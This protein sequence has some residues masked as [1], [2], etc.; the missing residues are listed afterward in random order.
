MADIIAWALLAV[1]VTISSGTDDGLQRLWLVA[2]YA[3]AMIWVVAPRLRRLLAPGTPLTAGRI[4]AVLAGMLLSAAFTEW[5]GL[6]FIFGAFAFGVAMPHEG[7]DRLRQDLL[8]RVGGVSSVMLLPV[9]FVVA[10]LRVDLSTMDLTALG[11]LGLIVLVAVTGKFVGA[12]LGARLNGLPAQESSAVAVLM[13]TRGLT[14]LV[15]LSIGLQMG[16]LDER[17]YTL[18]VLMAL[19]TTAMAGP[20]LHLCY[21]SKQE[22]DSPLG[23][24]R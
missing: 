1:V 8:D 5:I 20:L 12:F 10:G 9:F 15:V 14:E 3:A 7:T 2:P 4:G 18:M 6:H 21:R 23:R 13:N 24:G 22:L 19:L 17:L 16:V 11:I